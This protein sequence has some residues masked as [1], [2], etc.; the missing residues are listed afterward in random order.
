VHPTRQLL[1]RDLRRTLTVAVHPGP[2][3]GFAWHYHPVV[4]L[5]LVLRGYGTRLI[6]D[7]FAEFGPGDLVLAGSGLPHTWA[8]EPAAP[9]ATATAVW[10]HVDPQRLAGLPER[11]DLEP[12]FRLGRRGLEFPARLPRVRDELVAAAA[13][14]RLD[15][16]AGLLVVLATLVQHV[17]EAVPRPVVSSSA[18]SRA[19]RRPG[20]PAASARYSSTAAS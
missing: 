12:L 16:L 4:E 8:S 13:Q 15:Q 11:E 7:A 5:T 6:G 3:F 19:G 1:E 18:G 9:T 14:G 2:A 17:D 20:L 10:A